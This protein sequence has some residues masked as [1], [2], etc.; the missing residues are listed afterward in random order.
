MTA[1]RPGKYNEKLQKRFDDLLDALYDDIV[2]GD[3]VACEKNYWRWGINASIFLHLDISETKFYEWADES[4][5]TYAPKFRESYKRYV[6]IKM[7]MFH[8]A[9][10]VITDRSPALA[11]FKCKNVL[12]EKD[13][14]MFA[15]G[16][17]DGKDVIPDTFLDLVNKV[18][19]DK[20]ALKKKAG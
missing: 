10:P 9:T 18:T 17:R 2:K 7:A 1:G 20:E 5:P 6:L 16:G 11:I 12:G 3:N 8:F 15:V 14:R 4:S 13:E 19:K